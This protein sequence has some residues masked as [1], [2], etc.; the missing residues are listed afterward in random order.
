M[1]TAYL[2][3]DSQAAIEHIRRAFLGMG[4]DETVDV[5]QL[6]GSDGVLFNV[7]KDDEADSL[8][9]A[10]WREGLAA[11]GQA[12]NVPDVAEAR[13][14]LVSCRSEDLFASLVGSAVKQIPG[15]AWV[16][17]GNDVLWPA[18]AIDPRRLVL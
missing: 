18:E 13:A 11:S 9:S 10:D 3:A 16:L 7:D 5:L 12:G 6:W 17:D 1:K 14:Y 8:M 15:R 4:A 2:I